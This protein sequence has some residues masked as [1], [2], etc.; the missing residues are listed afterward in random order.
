MLKKMFSLKIFHYEFLYK[1]I[2]NSRKKNS[3][4]KKKIK[5]QK[6]IQTSAAL[7]CAQYYDRISVWRHNTQNC[8][9]GATSLQRGGSNASFWLAER[10]RPAVRLTHRVVLFETQWSLL[11]LFCL[12]LCRRIFVCFPVFFLSLCLHH[13]KLLFLIFFLCN[14]SPILRFNC[15]LNSFRN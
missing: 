10:Q 13:A 5:E 6:K 3:K 2:R 12:P 15:L 8:L 9:F 1:K 4:N 14:L 11:L 7:T